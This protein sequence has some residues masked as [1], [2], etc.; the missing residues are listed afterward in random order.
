[1]LGNRVRFLSIL[2]LIAAATVVALI[3]A[4]R[5]SERFAIRHRT[6]ESVCLVS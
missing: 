6:S 1:M 5:V 4:A 3:G 2:L